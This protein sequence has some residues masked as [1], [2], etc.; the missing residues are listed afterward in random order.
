MSPDLSWTMH[1]SPF[2]SLERGHVATVQLRISYQKI[3][4]TPSFPMQSW[5]NCLLLG[6]SLLVCE[7][8]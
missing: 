5:A 6:L 3:W 8:G 2:S 1:P 7:M 4:H